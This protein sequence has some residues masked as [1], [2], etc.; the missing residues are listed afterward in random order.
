MDSVTNWR[1]PR[2]SSLVPSSS[3]HVPP[4][5]SSCGRTPLICLSSPFASWDRSSAYTEPGMPTS[6]P[7]SPRYAVRNSA[8]A[9]CAGNADVGLPSG[10]TVGRYTP[11][12]PTCSFSSRLFVFG[13][14]LTS[15]NCATPSLVNMPSVGRKG[16]TLVCRWP[17]L[18]V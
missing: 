8:G 17:Y 6:I 3:V 13:S 15:G 18:S 7:K 2:N 10:L 16:T 4:G 14:M 9:R 1:V 5:F 12:K 11:S